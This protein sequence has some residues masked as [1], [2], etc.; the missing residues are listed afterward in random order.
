MQ[1]FMT[2]PRELES[3]GPLFE[4]LGSTHPSVLIGGATRL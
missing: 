3:E 4:W 1:A 2:V